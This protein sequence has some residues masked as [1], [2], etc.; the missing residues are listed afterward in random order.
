MDNQK[1]YYAFEGQ[2]ASDGSPHPIT[3]RMSFYGKIICFDTFADR[4]KYI[5]RHASQSTQDILVAGSKYNLRRFCLGMS[6]AAYNEYL[7]CVA[8]NC[9]EV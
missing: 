7:S 9:M 6:V 2:N 1:S 5:E 4:K 8:S 3:G